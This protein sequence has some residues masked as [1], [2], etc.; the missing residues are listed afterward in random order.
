MERAGYTKLATKIALTTL[1]RRGMITVTS[2]PSPDPNDKGR[3]SVYAMRDNGVGYIMSNVNNIELRNPNRR[4]QLVG[5]PPSFG[6]AVP[7]LAMGILMMIS[8]SYRMTWIPLVSRLSGS[9][10]PRFAK[11]RPFATLYNTIQTLSCVSIRLDFPAQRTAGGDIGATAPMPQAAWPMWV[12]IPNAHDSL[13]D[14]PRPLD[15]R[16]ILRGPRS[17][18]SPRRKERGGIFAQADSRGVPQ[19]VPAEA[20]VGEAS[21]V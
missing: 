16:L 7:P 2:V 6:W 20:D 13:P 3:Y 19:I 15:R 5:E 18:A 11:G 1:V 12:T 14:Q 9:S 21:I 8:H 4:P 10:R 17:L